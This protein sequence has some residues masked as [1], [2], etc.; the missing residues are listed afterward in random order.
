LMG[1]CGDGG[2]G[3]RGRRLAQECLGFSIEQAKWVVC[4]QLNIINEA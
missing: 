1:Y 3:D 2:L 4:A